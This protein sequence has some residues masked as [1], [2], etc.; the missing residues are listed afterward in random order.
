MTPPT[1]TPTAVARLP[2]V[3]LLRRFANVGSDAALRYASGIG[4]RTLQGL[5]SPLLPPLLA[6]ADAISVYS[7]LLAC[8]LAH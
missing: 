3:A 2:T 7:L 1:L 5:R 8:Q 6:E 4:E